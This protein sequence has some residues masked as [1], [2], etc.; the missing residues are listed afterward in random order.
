MSWAPD[1]KIKFNCFNI[2]CQVEV[3]INIVGR[4]INNYYLIVLFLVFLVIYVMVH[5]AKVFC[6]FVTFISLLCLPLN[7]FFLIRI[8]VHV[9]WAA[10][11]DILLIRY[12]ML[13]LDCHQTQRLL[14]YFDQ[15]NHLTTIQKIILSWH[16]GG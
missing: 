12:L 6:I 13:H 2:S 9:L 10:S 5:S 8:G 7:S 1:C 11:L 4:L 3:S 15:W 16:D 14:V